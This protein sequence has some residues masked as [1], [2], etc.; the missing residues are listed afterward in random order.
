MNARNVNYMF[1]QKDSVLQFDW[2]LSRKDDAAW[3]D[4]NVDLTLKLPLNAKVTI[5]EDLNNRVSINNISV[6][7]CKSLNKT[8][9]ATSATFIM[10]NDGP[11]CK[12]DTV[13]VVKT[14]KQL[15][16]A[17]KSKDAETIAKYRAQIDSVKK[18]DSLSNE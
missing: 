5:D 16:S 10:T 12:V 2:R 4:E 13:V 9:N 18:A 11:Q 15:D 1:L 6:G 3:H 8:E 17:R 7:D 14:P